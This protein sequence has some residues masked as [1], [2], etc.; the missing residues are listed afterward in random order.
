MISSVGSNA[1]RM[2]SDNNRE[3]KCVNGIRVGYTL[4]IYNGFGYD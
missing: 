4:L 1:K 2:E 3:K